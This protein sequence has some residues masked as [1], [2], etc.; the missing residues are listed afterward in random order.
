LSFCLDASVL[1]PLVLSEPQHPD[2]AGFLRDRR[3]PFTVTSFAAGE[4]V[5]AIGRHVRKDRLSAADAR[6]AIADLEAWYGLTSRIAAMEDG[7]IRA[8]TAF[9][10]RFDLALRLPDAIHLAGAARLA[11]P[12]LTLDDRLLRAADQL[13]IA[14]VRPG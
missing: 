3:G 13:G 14:A 8:A 10:S 7:D 6:E 2:V 5:S 9:V 4:A 11:V 1:V 12:L